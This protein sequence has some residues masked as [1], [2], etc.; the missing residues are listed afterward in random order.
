MT[1]DQMIDDILRR[2][3]GYVNHPSDKGGPT[4]Y[5][6]TAGTLAH[7][8]GQKSVPAETVE[9][10][11]EST[12]RE[13]YR[14]NYYIG[15]GIDHLPPG[16]QPFLFDCAVNHGPSR[17]IKFLQQVCTDLGQDV[18]A[19]GKLGPATRNAAIMV[20]AKHG[21]DVLKRLIV[22]RGEFYHAIVAG[23]SSQRVFFKGWLN[24]LTEFEPAIGE[25]TT[26]LDMWK[27][28]ALKAEQALEELRGQFKRLSAA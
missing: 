2:E 11:P 13:I 10:M 22:K 7:W 20:V 17:G 14:Q 27:V 28:R 5:G 9:A 18:V 26:T 8:Y 6:I 3:G 24:R 12:A 1:V 23:N 16:I 19:D 25:G 15:P 4:K 21:N